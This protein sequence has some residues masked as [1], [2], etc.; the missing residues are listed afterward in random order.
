MTDASTMTDPAAIADALV[1]SAVGGARGPRA[2]ARFHT[3][4]VSDIR[5]LTADAV[6]VTFEIPERLV[7]E[8]RYLPGQYVALRTTL[9]GEDARRSYSLCRPPSRTSISVA[10]KRDH[11]GRFSTW[12]QE[13]LRVGDELEVMSPQGGFTSSIDDLAAVHVAGIAAGSGITPLMSLATTVL[14][15]SATARF[16]LVYTNRSTKDV[17]FLEELADLKDRYPTRFALHHVLS[18]EQRAAPVLSGRIDEE[19]LGRILDGL[20]RPETV[21]EWFLCGPL[22]L[23]QLCRETLRVRSVEDERVRFELFSTG[24]ERRGPRPPVVVRDDA[25]TVTI[26]FTLD[27]QSATVDSPVDAN[28]S[29][30]DAALRVRPDVP[31]ACAGGVCGTCR[32]RVLAGSVHMTDNYALE[33]DE[34]DRGY[35]LTCQSHPT[36]D[37]VTVDY[38]S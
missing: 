30:L 2:R 10:I 6:E 31:F 38:D 34:L 17:M 15:R 12:A 36:T 18:R 35:V 27:G 16:S 20:V 26:E 9:D 11:G 4:A 14:A 25:P 21:D 5:P 29:I 33:P 28:E 7:D 13:G 32:A 8:Y 23:V 24:E 1:S 37:R 22:E 19:R 3:L